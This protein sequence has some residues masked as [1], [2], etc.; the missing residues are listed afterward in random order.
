M[1]ELLKDIYTPQFFEQF[2]QVVKKIIPDFNQDS[3]LAAIHNDGWDDKELKQRIRH[4]ATTLND[5]LPHDYPGNLKAIL[6]IISELKNNG[7]KEDSLEYMFFPDFIELYGLAHYD[8]SINAIEDITQFSSCEFAVRPF[9]ITYKEEMMERILQWSNH[10]NAHVR[11]L[12]SEGCRPRLPW[13]MALPPFK[14]DP[15]P[16]LPILESLRDD[17][18]EYVRRSVANNL[19]DISKD[20]PE[21]VKDIAKRWKGRSGETDSLVKH[22][23]RTLLK[24]GDREVMTLFGFGDV[25]HIAIH[26]LRILTPKVSA[27]GFL[28]FT[29]TLENTS[30]KPSKIRLEYGVFFQKANGTLSRKIFKI[31]ERVYPENSNTQISKRHSFKKISTRRYYP[32]LHEVSVVVNGNVFGKGEFDYC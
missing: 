23:C 11:R 5:H 1:P 21:L 26:D 12:A 22:A 14:K 8:I 13:A 4:I 7:T 30:D 28:E 25:S 24:Q 20:H 17:P 6:S 31:S 18:S 16:I 29:F 3:F 10:E 15:S 19:N 32:G 27:G 2:L 9:I